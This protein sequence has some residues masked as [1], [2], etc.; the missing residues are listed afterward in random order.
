MNPTVS[1][2]LI[3]IVKTEPG[4]FVDST[5][6]LTEQKEEYEQ[7]IN[8]L[9]RNH[10]D[11]IY[12]LCQELEKSSLIIHQ[13]K[14]ELDSMRISLNQKERQL[15]QTSIQDLQ[16]KNIELTADNIKLKTEL[17]TFKDKYR[18]LFNEMQDARQ[19]LLNMID[20]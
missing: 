17:T 12:K 10:D 19:Y 16:N 9:Q 5:R 6:E 14:I 4:V 3:R 18:I 7:E 20:K 11:Q 1:P 13:F 2:N 8:R 15:K